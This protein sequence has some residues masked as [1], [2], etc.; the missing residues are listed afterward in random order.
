[1]DKKL[2]EQLYDIEER[3]VAYQQIIHAICLS[4]PKAQADAVLAL[5]ANDEEQTLARIQPEER[6]RTHMANENLDKFKA[7]LSLPYR[8]SEAD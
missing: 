5:L 1:M 7:A 2:F 8:I 4:L 3:L 6:I